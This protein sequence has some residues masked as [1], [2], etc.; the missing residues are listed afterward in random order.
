MGT[1]LNRSEASASITYARQN[2][3]SGCLAARN[4]ERNILLNRILSNGTNRLRGNTRSNLFPIRNG[5]SAFGVIR[6]VWDR[7]RLR[8]LSGY[9]RTK[10]CA[11]SPPY[12]PPNT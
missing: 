6:E 9:L 1:S 8:A 3:N 2:S 11:T 12:D 4:V 10:Y 7:I 5:V